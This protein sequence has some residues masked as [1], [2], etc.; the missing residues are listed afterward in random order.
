V[1][2]RIL[3]M[4]KRKRSATDGVTMRK[5]LVLV[6]LALMA[7][8]AGG[9]HVR[10]TPVEMRCV[11]FIHESEL[12]QDLVVAGTEDDGR[13]T[14]LI[15]GALAYVVGPGLASA[16]VGM[17]YQVVRPEGR[18]RD[19]HTNSVVGV[20]YKEAGTIRIDAV[21]SGNAIGTVTSSCGVIFKG[22]LLVP[23]RLKPGTTFSGTMSNRLTEHP[24]DGVASSIL[25]A[26][27]DRR[28]MGAGSFCFIGVGAREGVKI[29]DRFTIYRPQPGFDRKQLI[30]NAPHSMTTYGKFQTPIYEAKIVEILKKRNLPPR[31]LGDMVIVDV[32]E[33]TS[34]AKVMN[35]RSE[36]HLGDLVVRR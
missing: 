5:T 24:S 17:T 28:E 1:F 30:V 7:P 10:T 12:P 19:H 31:V 13:V 9:Q 18:I 15:E 14:H 21:H 16:K 3:K 26:K 6:F 27:D 11:G 29:G 23:L 22:D 36:V 34:A 35:S 33:T 20:Y 4:L 8:A 2:A 25:V 32:A